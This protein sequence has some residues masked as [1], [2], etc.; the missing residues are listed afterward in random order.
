MSTRKQK[1]DKAAFADKLY[2]AMLAI[3]VGIMPLVIRIVARNIP[4][5][6]RN[7]TAGPMPDY[8][9]ADFFVS[10]KL[11]VLATAVIVMVFYCVGDWLTGGKLPQFKLYLKRVPIILS[12]VYL[13]FVFISTLRPGYAFT[14]WFGTMERQ[15]GMIMWL[16]YFVVFA[17]A[18]FYVREI[19]YT[20]P[21]LLGL[22]FSSVIMGVIGFSQLIGRNFL[23]TNFAVSL[24]SLGIAIEDFT[25]RFE[26][27]HGTLYNPNTFGKY[28][29]MVAP[30]LLLCSFVY[31]GKLYTK[32]AMF[33]G[34]ALMLVG[35]F[36]SGSLGGLIGIATATGVLVV[37]YVC[38][39]I[40]SRENKRGTAKAA[41]I[42]A[43]VAVLIAASLMFA[44]PLNYRFTT[45][46]NRLQE[47]AAAETTTHERF[48]FDG[49]SMYAYREGER[50][51][52]AT[53]NSFDDDM[54]NWITV[55]DGAGL[56]IAPSNIT[57]TGQGFPFY[58]FPIPGFAVLN[59][60]RFPEFFSIGTAGQT[61]NFFLYFDN[62]TLYGR[63][64]RGF[65][66]IDLSEP[67]PA[68]GFEGRETWGSGRGYIWSRSFPLMPG[69]AIIGSGPDTFVNVF[70]NHDMVGLHLTFNCPYQIVDKAH[71]I[72]IQ[73][74][75]T[76]GGL[77]A[78]ALFGL[79]FF[80]MAT[81]FWGLVTSKDE[82]HYS[83][84]LRLG[85]LAGIS[86]FVM[87]GMATDSTIGSTG[88]FFV[89]LGMGYGL[90]WFL[91]NKSQA[92]D[93]KTKDAAKPNNKA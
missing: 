17:A 21:I 84:A 24:M 92:A 53:V 39:F 4:R 73:T 6:I 42:F 48:A 2:S 14:S 55:R 85:L 32:I 89:L 13:A 19:K 20:K 51:L 56:E 11:W 37:T 12:L 52:S 72:F 7:L 63:D 49:D 91:K 70:P 3:V 31:E 57:T 38:Y 22:T 47:A 90:N 77:S 76:T 61:N 9:Y 93:N 5:D 41:G 81:T 75:I 25:L 28:T 40:K 54:G 59:V 65:S 46:L 23:G 67:V 18:M 78:I 8:I 88:V 60:T 33:L 80:Y 1:K 83:F 44:A 62:G 58:E 79:F 15:E 74:W 86:G 66:R 27:A 43:G 34:G 45:L 87:A 26:I 50:L 35:V 10:G 64:R 68:W 71:N 30:V 36:A 82:P 16:L 69:T 29:A